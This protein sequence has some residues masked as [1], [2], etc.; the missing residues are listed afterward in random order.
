[1]V[2]RPTYSPKTTDLANN[3]AEMAAILERLAE[4]MTLEH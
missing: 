2:I 3:I 4:D 1:M